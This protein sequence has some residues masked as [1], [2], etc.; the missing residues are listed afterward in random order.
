[1]SQK[2]QHFS[3]QSE[4]IQSIFKYSERSEG[5]VKQ[6]SALSQTSDIHITATLQVYVS[7]SL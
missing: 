7:I 4:E 6:R 3:K 2:M 5:N 1:M